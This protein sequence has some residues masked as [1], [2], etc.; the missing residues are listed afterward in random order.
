MTQCGRSLPEDARTRPGW[1][2]ASMAATGLIDDVR[3]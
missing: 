3:K 2:A 1:E